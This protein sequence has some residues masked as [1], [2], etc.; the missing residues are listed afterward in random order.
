MHITLIDDSIAFDGYSPASQPMG[1]AEKA[2]ASLPGALARLGHQV[3]VVNRCLRPIT[4]EGAAWQSWEAPRPARTDLLIA[5]RKP[6]LLDEVAE[7]GRRILWLTAPAGYLGKPTNRKILDR[8]KPTLVFLGRGHVE[9]F[10]QW[11]D[12]PAAVI[13]PGLRAD[14]IDDAPQCP[15]SPPRLIVTTHP[16]HGLDWLLRLWV[17]RLHPARPDALLQVTSVILDKGQR[18]EEVPA[19]IRPVLA[20]ALAARDQGVVIRRPTGDPGMA[21][22]YRA[23]RL[24]L[25]PGNAADMGCFT[26]M[27]SQACGLPA[28]ARD[29]GAVRERLRDGETGYVVPDDDAFVNVVLRLL[30]D[31]DVF[32]SLSRD[33]RMLY[34]DR[35]WDRVAAEF[36]FLWRNN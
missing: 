31:E 24:H 18:G 2:F 29:L 8:H 28:V 1:G 4:V 25:Y 19:D 7:A 9:T 14:Y 34:R 13:P 27:E 33:A 6:A 11:R 10:P 30:S 21:E 5:L 20:Q 26:L 16:L 15:D 22:D 35:S 17:T 36:E 32:W 3:T 12:Y 23:S